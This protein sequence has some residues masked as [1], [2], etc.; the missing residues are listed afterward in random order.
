MAA[1]GRGTPLARRTTIGL[2][3]FALCA[4]AVAVPRATAHAAPPPGPSVTDHRTPSDG[5]GG[6]GHSGGS[7]DPTPSREPTGTPAPTPVP[8]SSP[9]GAPPS[10]TPP[11]SGTPVGQPALPGQTQPP[12]P[13]GT[14][15]APAAP[16]TGGATML[17][18]QLAQPIGS[19]GPSGSP[20]ADIGGAPAIG[21]TDTVRLAGTSVPLWLVAGG[22]GLLVLVVAVGLVLTLR[23]RE[24]EPP[25]VGIQIEG[26]AS[27]KFG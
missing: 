23:D 11:P 3:A 15:A 6:G 14:G 1:G 26:P 16:G 19:A 8:T 24:P 9:T 17:G 7:H 12:R 18:R 10:R 21:P 25:P 27:V 22:A 5:H 4:L 2:A 20:V 13:S